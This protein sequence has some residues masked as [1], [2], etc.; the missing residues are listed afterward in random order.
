MHFQIKKAAHPQ[1]PFESDCF[2]GERDQQ[3][4]VNGLANIRDHYYSK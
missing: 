4:I 3:H 2:G 1:E